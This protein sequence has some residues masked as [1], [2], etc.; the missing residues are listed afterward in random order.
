MNDLLL[1]N[2]DP[3]FVL[4][5]WTPT[6]VWS[7]K[8]SMVWRKNDSGI[9]TARKTRQFYFNMGEN[10]FSQAHLSYEIWRPGWDSQK[11]WVLAWVNL[12]SD[13]EK[14]IFLIHF[15]F[16][17]SINYEQVFALSCL[18]GLGPSAKT[19]APKCNQSKRQNIT[20]H[21]F[22]HFKGSWTLVYQSKIQ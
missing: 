21:Y 14:K 8:N 19:R 12:G 13:F 3:F 11:N 5:F 9:F 7:R 16:S 4:Y 6:F 15:T 10:H 20:V 17:A 2:R 1:Q 22:F 18:T